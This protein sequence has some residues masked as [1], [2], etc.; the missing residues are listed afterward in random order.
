MLTDADRCLLLMAGAHF[1]A[2]S[3]SHIFSS[4]SSS[5]FCI[6]RG[7]EGNIQHQTKVHLRGVWSGSQLV[8]VGE[9]DQEA[10]GPPKETISGATCLQSTQ[11]REH[12]P[13]HGP[14][15]LGKITTHKPKLQQV[16]S[17]SLFLAKTSKFVKTEILTCGR[18]ILRI[19]MVKHDSK[20]VF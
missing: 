19:T 8:W 9:P 7:S 3:L 4:S 11:Y 13:A 10:K 5:A 18:Y 16:A 17:T 1:L 2:L 6:P 20:M 14:S 12:C 15:L